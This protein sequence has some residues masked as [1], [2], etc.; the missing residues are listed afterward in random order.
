[1]TPDKNWK[2]GLGAFVVT[3]TSKNWWIIEHLLD[4]ICVQKEADC[5]I[6]QLNRPTVNLPST[7]GI[8]Y[9]IAGQF[10][11]N[12]NNNNNNILIITIKAQLH[13]QKTWPIRYDTHRDLYQ[14]EE[15]NRRSCKPNI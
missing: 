11:S 15:N 3:R 12:S 13:T 9:F 4:I 8:I 6:F 7:T 10:Y 1:M 14:S 2:S 5:W